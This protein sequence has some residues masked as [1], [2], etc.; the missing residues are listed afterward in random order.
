MKKYAN[1]SI[2]T[3]DVYWSNDIITSENAHV[4][5]Y[6]YYMYQCNIFQATMYLNSAKRW[7]W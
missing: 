2:G 7:I 5:M 4:A 6:N 1:Y 3:D